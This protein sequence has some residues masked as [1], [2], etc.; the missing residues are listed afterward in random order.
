MIP[1]EFN[2]CVSFS[3]RRCLSADIRTANHIAKLILSKGDDATY[4]KY[5]LSTKLEHQK[6]PRANS[7][8]AIA[9]ARKRPIGDA[10]T[11]KSY[12][13]ERFSSGVHGRRSL[14]TR[15]FVL[16]PLLTHIASILVQTTGTLLEIRGIADT[17]LTLN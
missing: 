15:R 10:R 11:S 8:T 9:N 3:A 4:D 16:D 17:S 1:H 7:A 14:Q 6:A 2:I 12:C 5:L 13:N